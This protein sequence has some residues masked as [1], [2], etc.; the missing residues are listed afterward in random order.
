MMKTLKVINQNG[1]C[2]TTKDLEVQESVNNPNKNLPIVII[3]AVPIGLAPAAYLV[4][5]K[6]AFII[7]AA[8]QE[9]AHNTRT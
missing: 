9:I 7:L 2:C 4:E 1:S 3:S 6:P 8:G 5:Q